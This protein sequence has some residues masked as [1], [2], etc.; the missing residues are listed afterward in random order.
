MGKLQEAANAYQSALELQ[1]SLE[2]ASYNKEIIEKMIE[3]QKY[4]L[5]CIVW[6]QFIKKSLFTSDSL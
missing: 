6:G 2:D 5:C 1:P 3:Q 4:L